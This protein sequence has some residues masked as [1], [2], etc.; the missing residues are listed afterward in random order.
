MG[1]SDDVPL[2]EY[3]KRMCVQLLSVECKT[4]EVVTVAMFLYAMLRAGYIVRER[5]LLSA[6]LL[7]FPYI[8]VS[9]F[10]CYALCMPAA[11]FTESSSHSAT[12]S[13]L[14]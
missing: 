12:Y 9:C 11:A 5:L 1:W 14:A 6:S 4:L 13:S 8:I 3:T 2:L 7:S 10:L